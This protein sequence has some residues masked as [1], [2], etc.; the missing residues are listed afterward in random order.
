MHDAAKNNSKRLL[1]E[2][3]EDRLIDFS[4]SILNLIDTIPGSK[5]ASHICNQLIRSGTSPALNYGEAQ[6]AESPQ[7]FI[8]KMKL[9]LKELRETMIC[10][11]IICRKPLVSDTAS[12]KMVIK[13]NDELISIFVSSI[14]TAARHSKD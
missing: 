9:C 13:E 11:K 4:I 6:S 7:D 14:N 1:R 8:H 10:L 12:I 3:L 5:S 2:K